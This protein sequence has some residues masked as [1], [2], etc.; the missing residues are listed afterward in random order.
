MPLALMA[1]STKYP[2]AVPRV[3]SFAMADTHLMWVSACTF[4]TQSVSPCFG[5]PG[6]APMFAYSSLGPFLQSHVEGAPIPFCSRSDCSS[7]I[8]SC[9]AGQHDHAKHAWQSS[10]YLL[11]PVP[12]GALVSIGKCAFSS[13]Q[14]RCGPGVLMFNL[15]WATH[16]AAHNF[17][18]MQPVCSFCTWACVR[19]LDRAI[20]D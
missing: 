13:Q 14:P 16:R 11:S 18:H 5:M 3:A 15:F 19:P 10:Q 9:E 7:N 12:F 6:T 2:V 8:V 1:K 20:A 17:R 4:E